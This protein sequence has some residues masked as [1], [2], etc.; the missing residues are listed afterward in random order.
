MLVRI[1]CLGLLA[2]GSVGCG[3]LPFK[4]DGTNNNNEKLD[5]PDP[6]KKYPS[7]TNGAVNIAVAPGGGLNAYTSLVVTKK[8]EQA[9]GEKIEKMFDLY[10][11]LS[12]GTLAAT[13]FMNGQGDKILD[14]FKSQV[15][16][17]FPD[18]NEIVEAVKKNL[19]AIP[20]IIEDKNGERRNAFDKALVANIGDKK[21]SNN[22]GNRFVL[23]ASVNGEPACYADSNIKLPPACAYK[24]PDGTRVVDGVINSSNFQIP[25]SVI[26]SYLPAQFAGLAAGL[27]PARAPLFKLQTGPASNNK[28]FPLIDAFPDAEDLLDGTSPLPLAIDYLLQMK[29]KDNAEHNIVVFDNGS[30]SIAEYSNKDYRDEIKMDANGY[31]RIE[32]NGIVINVFLL[33]I[34]VAKKQFDAWTFDHQDSHWAAAENLVNQEINGPRKDLFERA[35]TAVKK[36]LQ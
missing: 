36:N 11:G 30:A 5:E 14:T 6:G 18:V 9:A 10:W 16:S 8:F 34:N 29:T 17:A 15:K 33:K 22:G 3:E 32:K 27:L 23:V 7:R 28:S 31:A 12:G 20:I 4:K 21:F 35:V 13:M 1:M 19:T 2:L 26:Q 24:S 25:K